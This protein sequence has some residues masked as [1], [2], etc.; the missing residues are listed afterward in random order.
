MLF[1]RSATTAFLLVGALFLPSTSATCSSS[2]DCLNGGTCDD[3]GYS[4]HTDTDILPRY[5]VCSEGFLGPDC[6]V[7]CPLDCKNG[8]HCDYE[9]N[10]HAFVEGASDFVCECP[11]D[12]EGTFCEELVRSSSKDAAK[13]GGIIAGIVVAVGVV[14]GVAAWIVVKLCKRKKSTDSEKKSEGPET[15]PNT[16]SEP[17]AGKKNEGTENDENDAPEDLP[18]IA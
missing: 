10:E 1:L 7:T 13:E 12:Y 9:S 14:V 6:G 11:R 8:G 2:D 15:A 16:G 17:G 4:K 3:I 18:D 5:C